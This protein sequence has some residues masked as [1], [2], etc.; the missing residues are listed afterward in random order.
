MNPAGDDAGS[1]TQR[2]RDGRTLGYAELGA[3]DGRPL[4][5]LHGAPGSRRLL[6]AR[7][8]VAG[9]RLLCPERPGYGLSTPRRGRTIL[10]FARDVLDLCDALGLERFA[11]A[12]TS[13][14]CPYAAA[15]AWYA[16]A[17]VNA[18]G[19]C[20]TLAPLEPAQ[21]R[22]RDA[23]MT[24][25]RRFAAA[26]IRRRPALAD[27]LAFLDALR[28]HQLVRAG[29]DRLVDELASR[30]PESDRAL[31]AEPDTYASYVATY[32]EAWRQGMGGYARDLALLV[33]PWGFRLEE[34]GVP[35]WLWHGTAD[36]VTPLY[37]GESVARAI[38]GCRAKFFAG[39][40]HLLRLAHW[41]EI[42]D[43][44]VGAGASAAPSKQE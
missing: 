10:D 3:S 25:F 38:P 26:A 44:L 18:L 33:K 8:E 35:T 36:S 4:V 12:A 19:L 5:F 13:G 43:T 29:V 30:S 1:R 9:V 24:P 16:P 11:V 28:V 7:D 32:Q 22:A 27:P 40:G 6:R 41:P 14:G 37:M 23:A 15:L 17:R 34:I 2:L 20:A 42:V 39:E 21:S 31:L